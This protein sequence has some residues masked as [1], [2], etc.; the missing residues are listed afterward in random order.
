R[1]GGANG[2]KVGRGVVG[3]GAGP[4]ASQYLILGGKARALLNGRL[5]VTTEDVRSVAFPVLRHRIVTTFNADAEGV[6]TD[7]IIQKLIAAIPLPQD[8]SA[9]KV[10]RA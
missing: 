9:A 3:G 7:D 5:H 6:T 10:R 4:R 8:E 2:P 1:A